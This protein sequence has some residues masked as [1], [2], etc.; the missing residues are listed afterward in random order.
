MHPTF[1]VFTRTNRLRGV[2]ESASMAR[3]IQAVTPTLCVAPASG[4]TL[5]ILKQ[6][7]DRGFKFQAPTRFPL[8]SPKPTGDVPRGTA[9]HTALGAGRVIESTP[10][11][12]LV[13]LADG[14]ERRFV[15]VAVMYA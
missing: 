5:R 6:N 1:A 4:K 13:K 3:Q 15:R 2:V 10:D 12:V 8:P 9:V 11:K 14:S 7:A